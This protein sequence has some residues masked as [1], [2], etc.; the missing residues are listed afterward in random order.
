MVP[1][2]TY[3]CFHLQRLPIPQTRD[4]ADSFLTDLFS[5]P[6]SK[7]DFLIRSTCLYFLDITLSLVYYLGTT[8][9]VFYL[10]LIVAEM[11]I[12]KTL[13]IFNYSKIASMNEYF[14]TKMLVLFNISIIFMNMISRLALREYESTPF[15]GY[16]NKE[17]KRTNIHKHP[18]V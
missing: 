2:R 4:W 17:N 5:D 13:Y 8:S 12:M 3:R 16:K 1:F 7:L 6:P 14:I 15:L 18:V 9:Y 10:S 11:V